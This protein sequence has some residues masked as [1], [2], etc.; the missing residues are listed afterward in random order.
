MWWSGYKRKREAGV[1]IAVRS[2]K[3]II[4][5]NLEQVS[6]RLMYIDCVCFGIKIRVISAYAPTESNGSESQ[7]YT[8]YSDL[9]KISNVQNRQLLIGG[10]M[11]ATADF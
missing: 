3:S 4:I 1:A 11:H 2:S 9:T 8:F 6:P 5:E 10:D 7:K